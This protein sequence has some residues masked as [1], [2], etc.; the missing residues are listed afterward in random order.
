MNESLVAESR[1]AWFGAADGFGTDKSMPWPKAK[2][3]A[4]RVSGLLPGILGATLGGVLLVMPGI[5]AAEPV[6]LDPAEVIDSGENGQIM[7]FEQQVPL[8]FSDGTEMTLT[9][10]SW[11]HLESY[12]FDQ[13]QPE[14]DRLSVRLVKGGLRTVTGSI[15]RRGS[16]DALQVQ[17]PVGSIGIRG[18]EF[19]TYYCSAGLC[20]EG[21]LLAV[22]DGTRERL[23]TEGGLYFEVATGDVRFANQAGQ[24]DFG[25]GEWGYATAR[26]LPP[27]RIIPEHSIPEPVAVVVPEPEDRELPDV[28]REAV[29]D[30][31]NLNPEV[32]ERYHAL[33]AAENTQAVARG[34][35]YPQIDTRFSAVRQYQRSSEFGNTDRNAYSAGITLNQLLYDGFFTQADVAR[36]GHAR[37]VRYHELREAAEQA[38]LEAVRALADVEKFRE[39]VLLAEDNYHAH[40]D[41][42]R[43]VEELARSGVG[44]GVDLEQATGRLALAE[45]NLLT[46]IANLHDVSARFQRVVGRLPSE[47]Y[48]DFVGAVPERLLPG[49]VDQALVDAL[50][51]N[52]ALFAAV[53]NM[54]SSEQKVR[55]GQAAFHPQLDFQINATRRNTPNTLAVSNNDERWVNDIAYGLVLRYNLFRGFADRATV[56]QFKEELNVAREQKE[57]VCRN[58]RQTVA[59]AYNDIKVFDEQLAYLEQ[60]ARSTDL[61]RTAFQQQFLIGQRTL[62]DLLDIEN[63]FF[64]ARRAYAEALIDREVAKARTW[65]GLGRLLPALG[66]AREEMPEMD[67]D[68]VIDPEMIC[69]PT[70][71]PSL[72]VPR[73]SLFR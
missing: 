17:T 43:Q 68:T 18:T 24:F 47:D 28:L 60:H 72:D 62:L 16:P 21:M 58:V 15:G 73:V 3:Q 65:A 9:P 7:A 57:I 63:E 46:E 44:R 39:L 1:W 33:L 11:L 36:L 45:S 20:N 23:L 31:I 40:L 29:L 41:V 64:E 14:S 61:V 10:G 56:G 5:G 6:F 19:D 55:V 70:A 50:A 53:E 67:S 12:N 59:I 4:A 37:M 22:A 35:Y 48:V 38:A 66:L 25:A 27:E 30:A 52:P 49:T 42:Y 32:Q 2:P 51:E 71:V 54:L 69:P 26:T 34:R 13:T 8:R